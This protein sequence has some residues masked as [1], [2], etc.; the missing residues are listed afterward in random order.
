[1]S[2]SGGYRAKGVTTIECLQNGAFDGSFS[3]TSCIAS[4]SNNHCWK[5]L[6]KKKLVLA[7]C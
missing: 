7:K 4:K 2:C 1:M 5:S 3:G 6:F